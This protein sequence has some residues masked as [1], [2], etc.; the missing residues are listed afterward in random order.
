MGK[1]RDTG[2]LEFLFKVDFFIY[3]NGLYDSLFIVFLLE[4]TPSWIQ[5]DNLSHILTTY[6]P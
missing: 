3:K 2:N 1:G 4:E 6:K 5:S